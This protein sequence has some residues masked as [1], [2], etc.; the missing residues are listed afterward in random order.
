[1]LPMTRFEPMTQGNTTKPI[2]LPKSLTTVFD[3]DV[4]LGNT[5]MG[6]LTV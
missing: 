5:E 2:M 6:G 4:G 1:M 3:K